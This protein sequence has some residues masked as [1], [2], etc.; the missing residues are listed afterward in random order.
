MIHYS[1]DRCKRIINDQ[2]VRYV[3]KLEARATIDHSDSFEIDDSEQ[4]EAIYETLERFGE[5]DS[6]VDEIFQKRNFD[7]CSN[8][9]HEIMKDPL[10]VNSR[11][12]LGFSQN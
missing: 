5:D 11:L 9:F 10:N 12:Q 3:L 6:I 4:L 1:C 2:E 8:C 7:V